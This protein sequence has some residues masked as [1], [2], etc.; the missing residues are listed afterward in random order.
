ML[1]LEVVL[2]SF[3]GRLGPPWG[4]LLALGVAFGRPKLVPKL[5]SH[6]LFDKNVNFHGILSFPMVFNGFSLPHGPL[7]VAKSAPRGVLERLGS[8]FFAFHWSLRFSMVF[9]SVWVSFSV[10]KCPPIG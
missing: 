4:G 5:S 8:C 2:A 1:I 6:R 7:K 9:G 10:P 3:W